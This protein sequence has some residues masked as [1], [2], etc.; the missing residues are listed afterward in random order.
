MGPHRSIHPEVMGSGMNTDSFVVRA[1][2]KLTDLLVLNILFIVCSLPVVTMGAAL[3]AMY[4]VS[5]RSVRYGDGYV[6]P[7]FFK[8]FKRNFAQSTAAWLIVLAAGALLF[9]D[10]RFF[11]ALSSLSIGEAGA[12]DLALSGSVVSGAQLMSPQVA[13]ICSG[14][15]YVIAF[16]LWAVV[17]WLFPVISKMDDSFGAQ[18]LNSAR[19]AFGFFIPYTLICM[20][21]Q[22]LAVFAAVNNVP[23]MMMMLVLGASGVSYICSFF[24]YKVFSKLIDEDPAGEDDPLFGDKPDQDA[25]RAGIISGGSSAEAADSTEEDV[26]S[27]ADYHRMKD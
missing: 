14:A 24:I 7:T 20:V 13:R 2:N 18:I 4:A 9:I 16:F 19:I 12:Q 22:G 6:V 10:L 23:F 5:L 27:Q 26:Q 17:I 11:G 1:L 3:T 25:E 21:I 8:A 15:A